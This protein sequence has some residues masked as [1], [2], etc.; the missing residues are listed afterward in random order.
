LLLWRLVVVEW[1]L[2][3]EELLFPP[4]AASTKVIANAARS[5]SMAVSGNLRIGR[6]P[7]VA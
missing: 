1:V 6:A 4:Q 5:V 2:F 3:E 7:I